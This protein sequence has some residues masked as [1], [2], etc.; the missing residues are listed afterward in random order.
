MVIDNRSDK[1][2]KY[3]SILSKVALSIDAVASA[4]LAAC[5]V[6]K[7]EIISFGINQKKTHTFQAKYSKNPQAIHL[8]SETDCI[9]NAMRFL[10]LKELSKSTL[11]I[12]RVRHSPF[13][14]QKVVQGLAKPCE[15]C[16]KAIVNFDLKRVVYTLNDYGYAVL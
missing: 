6:Y 2:T 14:N 8:H 11:Y 5:I 3:L 10:T 7:N 1:H 13:N 4:R 16:M 12:C 9:K 15:G